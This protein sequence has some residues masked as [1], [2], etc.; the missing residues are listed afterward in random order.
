MGFIKAFTGSLSST[1][2]DQWQDFYVPRSDIPETAA[3]FQ[4][5]PQSQN[6]GR[7]E[8]YKG[9]ENN[10][11]I[12][13]VPAVS[14]RHLWVVRISSTCDWNIIYESSEYH[15]TPYRDYPQHS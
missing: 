9:N 7:G 14:R 2:A 10:V 12:T 13:P 4:A 1:L 3:V 6:N 5:V 8:N 15:L 11:T